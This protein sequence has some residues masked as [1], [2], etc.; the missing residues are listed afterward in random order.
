[1]DTLKKAPL[2]IEH[3]AKELIKDD[4]I[5]GQFIY[6]LLRLNINAEQYLL[7]L[8]ETVFLVLGYEPDTI[9]EPV[10]KTYYDFV[11]AETSISPLEQKKSLDELADEAYQLIN[12]L[13]LNAGQYEKEVHHH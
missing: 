11:R 2:N 6:G 7:N 12:G 1:M 13:L 9:P 10:W 4:M 5:N 3:L 8:S